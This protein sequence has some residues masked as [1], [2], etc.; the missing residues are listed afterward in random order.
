MNHKFDRINPRYGKPIKFEFTFPEGF[1]LV[2]DTREQDPL[3]L[4]RIPRGLVIKRD[5]L[6]SGDYS[7]SGFESLV[8]VER[9]SP[10]DLFGSLGKGRDRFKAELDRLRSY[11]LKYIL[12]ECAEEDL[13]RHQKYSLMHPNS[14]RQ[15]IV[16][17]ELRYGIHFHYAHDRRSLERWL[18]DRFI[19]YYLL[20]RGG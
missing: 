12:I 13:F 14:I 7:I 15:S 16:S 2:I 20:K 9:K 6:P 17:I 19:K 5:Y 3:F 1:I 10:E 18:L 8:S 4:S 11:E